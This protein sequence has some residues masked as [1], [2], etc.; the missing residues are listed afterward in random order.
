MIIKDGEGASKFVKVIVK[1]AVNY[2][3]AKKGAFA[4]ANSMLVKTMLYGNDANWGRVIAA[5][6]Y[7]GIN[8]K[9]DKTDLIMNGIKV[10]SKG[11]ST[12]KDKEANDR[13]RGKE[14]IIMADLH[15]GKGTAV[16][17]TCDLTEEYVKINAE[18]RT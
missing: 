5:L 15:I 14:I 17:S 7:S 12:G 3:E 4:I 18:Y 10:A 2:E 9:E 6:G 11:K 16:V 1:N 13:L 8:I